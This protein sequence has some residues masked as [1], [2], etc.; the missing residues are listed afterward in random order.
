M[1]QREVSVIIPVFNREAIVAE[2]IES[3][4][5][6]D[7][8]DVQVVV[9]D[10]GSTDRS[11]DVV[12]EMAAGDDRIVVDALAVNSG[13][14][15]ARNRAF[16][17]ATFPVITFLD[18]DDLM[19]P[20]RL[21]T[22]LAAL[23]DE[24]DGIVVGCQKIVAQGDAEIPESLRVHS[25]T[26]HVPYTTTMCATRETFDRLGRFDESYRIGEDLEYLLRS[27]VLGIPM[28]KLEE[29]LV[30][31]RVFGDNLI[32]DQQGV[33]RGMIRAVRKHQIRPDQI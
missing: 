10:D 33:K 13:V 27:N 25:Q 17:L 14:S 26:E 2:A 29:D 22:Q 19:A 11:F 23:D 7:D 28:V 15:A 12:E 4:L 5:S 31:R 16:E 18:S 8:V 20:G 6:Q 30:I 24:P 9:V 1:I 21:R 32:A 3:V